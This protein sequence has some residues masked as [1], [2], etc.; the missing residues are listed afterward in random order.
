MKKRKDPKIKRAQNIL[1]DLNCPSDRMDL[2]SISNIICL[3]RN[4]DIYDY[5]HPRI[6]ELKSLLANLQ[7][8]IIDSLQRTQ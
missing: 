8:K 4:I 3:K 6:N 7:N 2:T 5:K 1:K